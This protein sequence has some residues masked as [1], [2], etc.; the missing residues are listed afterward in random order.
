MSASSSS[1]TAAPSSSGRVNFGDLMLQKAGRGDKL[2]YAEW[3]KQMKQQH[4]ESF[5]LRV[6]ASMVS[7]WT[8]AIRR[9]TPGN[10]L[11]ALPIEVLRIILSFVGSV[12]PPP[13]IPSRDE[14]EKLCHEKR[15]EEYGKVAKYYAD[16]AKAAALQGKSR[17]LIT[18]EVA[19]AAP[20]IFAGDD[21]DGG[22]SAGR[23]GVFGILNLRYGYEVRDSDGDPIEK[24]HLFMEDSDGFPYSLEWT[25]SKR[26]KADPKPLVEAF[27]RMEERN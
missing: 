7:A 4:D 22:R 17:L 10:C 11:P 25:E 24:A 26:N 9:I 27:R 3:T 2:S 15:A 6:L 5:R 8:Q 23:L 19:N 20:R 16:L 1:S 12:M 13:A 14:V 18:K 21:E